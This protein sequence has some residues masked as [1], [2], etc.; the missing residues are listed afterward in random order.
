MSDRTI[1]LL[2]L[3]ASVLASAFSAAAF[4]RATFRVRE[5]DGSLKALRRVAKGWPWLVAGVAFFLLMALFWTLA[6]VRLPLS[7]AY[8]LQSTDLVVVVIVS[9]LFL[10][11]RIG[12]RRALGACLILLGTIL[13]GLK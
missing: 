2:N 7:L 4:K 10:R 11:E 8:P 9:G 13:V 1:G 6:L 3:V 12:A 5:T